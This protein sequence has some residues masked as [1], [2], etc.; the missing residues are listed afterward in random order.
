M[1]VCAAISL[2]LINDSV[3]A[4]E[5]ILKLSRSSRM[6]LSDMARFLTIFLLVTHSILGVSRAMILYTGGYNRIKIHVLVGTGCCTVQLP[7]KLYMKIG[8]H[9]DIANYQ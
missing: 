2:H 9:F 3:K 4:A 6:L 8:N 5:Y 7:R 1:C